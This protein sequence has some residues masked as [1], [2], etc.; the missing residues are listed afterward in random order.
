MRLFDAF[1]KSFPYF[2]F[3]IA[4]DLLGPGDFQKE[5]KLSGIHLPVPFPFSGSFL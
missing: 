5:F 1:K 3:C 4:G 2:L